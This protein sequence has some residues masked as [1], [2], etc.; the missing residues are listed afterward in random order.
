[1]DLL[2]APR[3]WS[4]ACPPPLLAPPPRLQQRRPLVE[5]HAPMGGGTGK[6][7]S[8]AKALVAGGISGAIEAVISYPTE[9]VRASRRVAE[10]AGGGAWRRRTR[11]LWLWRSP[12]LRPRQT[13]RA[14]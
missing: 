4:L 8:P 14:R 5:A 1:M 10:A 6:K 3:W 11:P 13:A 9:C 12:K 2:A 7:R